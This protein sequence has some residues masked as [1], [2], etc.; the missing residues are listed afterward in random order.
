RDSDGGHPLAPGLAGPPW[1]D[2][3]AS[4]LAPGTRDVHGSL[5]EDRAPTS[6]RDVRER[7][8]PALPR[9]PRG[10]VPRPRALQRL[11]PRPQDPFERPR[12]SIGTP[13]VSARHHE[14][15]SPWRV[16]HLL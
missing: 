3:T 15:E 5:A 16:A 7:T 9:D 12:H 11:C 13:P 8:V 4:S 2:S 6:G 10:P 14:D 1:P